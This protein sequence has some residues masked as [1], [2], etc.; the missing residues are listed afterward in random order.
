MRAMRVVPPLTQEQPTEKQH[1]TSTTENLHY[2]AYGE[3]KLVRTEGL[4][5]SHFNLSPSTVT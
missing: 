4:M 5:K 1:R 3:K 2:G